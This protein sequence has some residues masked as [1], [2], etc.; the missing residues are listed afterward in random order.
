[1]R[2]LHFVEPGGDGAH[3]LVRDADGE[4][5]RLAVTDGL[6]AALRPAPWPRPQPIDGAAPHADVALTPRDIQVRVRAGEL[7]EDLAA[8]AGVSTDRIQKFAF[9]VLQERSRVASEARRARARQGAGAESAGYVVFGEAVDARFAAHGIDPT[10]VLWD[11]VREGDSPWTVSA[12]WRSGEINGLARWTFQLG[13]RIMTPL[14]DTATELLSDRP[15]TRPSAHV[16]EAPAPVADDVEEAP[17]VP[18]NVRRLPSRPD[19]QF[20]DQEALDDRASSAPPA[21]VM[22]LSSF[23][24][25]PADE[26][27]SADALADDAVSTATDRLPA[28]PVGVAAPESLDATPSPAPAAEGLDALF[29]APE[30]AGRAAEDDEQSRARIPSWDDILLGVRRKRD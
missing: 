10:T 28:P 27:P 7:P 12:A 2:E 26:T 21:P 8:E 22:P 24:A 3:L 6:R 9:A 20:F 29:P 11:S 5:F 23:F 25:Q 15:V 30:G 4:Q 14:D 17:A 19:D 16:V 13:A 1:M 18:S